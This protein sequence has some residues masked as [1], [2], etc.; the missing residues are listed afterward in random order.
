MT[1][2]G[3]ALMDMAQPQKAVTNESA[4]EDGL[5][6]E[7]VLGGDQ[8]AYGQL[9][10]KYREIVYAVAWRITR[11]AQEADDLAQETFIKAY[12]NLPGFRRESSFKTWLLRITTNASIN[13]T[14][15]GRISK[16][17]GEAPEDRQLMR[18]GLALDNMIHTEHRKQLRAA[19]SRLPPKQ[20]QA[21]MLKTYQEMTC[22]EVASTLSCSV[23]T[24]KANIFNALKRLKALLDQGV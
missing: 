2:R 19:I 5:L 14:K 10:S 22:E 20:R 8:G 16:D 7:R 3:I 12:Q 11:N 4:T 17:S 23:G 1:E 15:S 9:V 21:L 13:M 18:Q 6:I 24:V